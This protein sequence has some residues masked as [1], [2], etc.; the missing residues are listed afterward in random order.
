MIKMKCDFLVLFPLRW[1]R[2]KINNDTHWESQLI[3]S[4]QST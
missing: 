3:Q 2:A 4:F 1:L